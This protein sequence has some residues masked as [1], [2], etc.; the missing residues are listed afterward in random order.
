MQ[1][2]LHTNETHNVEL[3]TIADIMDC[4]NSPKQKIQV[5][6]PEFQR[7][8]VAPT[9]WSQNLIQS[10]Y[11]GASSDV[12][13]FRKL[14]DEKAKK[15]GF[16]FQ[17]LDGL[18]RI[19][20]VIDFTNNKFA[21]LYGK[22][23]RELNKSEKE[24]FLSYAFVLFVYHEA[25]SDEEAGET[26]CRINNANDLNDQEKNN[27]VPG[28]VSQIIRSQSRTG[29]IGQKLP[30]FETYVDNK[31]TRR[32]MGA[33]SMLPGVR[34]AYDAL[35]ARW[36][37]IEYDKQR[38]PNNVPFSASGINK[39][40]ISEM[41]HDSTMKCQYDNNG[42][43]IYLNDYTWTQPKAFAPIEKE[44]VRRAKMVYDWI[45]SDPELSR[46]VFKN[47]GT[48]NLLFDLTYAIEDEFGKGSVK[49]NKKFIRGV[50]SIITK[51]RNSKESE[52]YFQ[53]ML[54]SGT[55]H[56]IIEKV[57]WFIDEFKTDSTRYGL[58]AIDHGKISDS[59]KMKIFV[60][61][62]FK[63]WMDQEEAT[64]DELEAAHIEARALGGKNV[65]GNYVLVRK[66]YNR[67]MGT[68][69]PMDYKKKYFPDLTEEV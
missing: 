63:C 23:F 20:S 52:L 65:I 59:D 3:W 14:S 22:Y 2:V 69:T 26:F 47:P 16:K 32:N 36:Y 57:M 8:F 37:A 35:L 17:C 58:I 45:E 50:V 28:Y 54:G 55:G 30:I 46:K 12:I 7:D 13:H 41:Y 10:I 31:D 15:V 67:N 27:A 29:E 34:M 24:S 43:P 49:D 42:S 68:M 11:E 18:Q 44:V 6:P 9:E 56:D 21:D 40:L 61:Q 60:K 53:R 19:T 64:I 25:M 38:H 66:Q 48:I 51:H 1:K 39:K 4:I 5:Q 33:F 62:K